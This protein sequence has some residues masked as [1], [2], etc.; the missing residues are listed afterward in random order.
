MISINFVTVASAML[1]IASAAPSQLAPRDESS[2]SKTAQLRLADSSVDRYK[3]LP[4]DEDFV[5][6]FLESQ[7]LFA[8]AKSFPALVGTGAAFAYTT[9]DACSMS[10]LHLH[11]RATEL[12]TVTSGSI[13]TEM[14][15]E[16]AVFDAD[17]Q[18]RVIRTELGP[19]M[20][21]VF[22]A[23]SFHTQ[24]NVDCKPA[25]FVAAFTSEDPG[26]AAVVNGVFALSD[27]VISG[28]FGEAI[29]GEDIDKIRDALPAG[30]GT[31]ID[32][33]LERCNMQKRV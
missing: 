8:D 16:A 6:N 18:Q 9:L 11:P 3:L 19:G 10:F 30:L 1:A 24:L 17:D 25:T 33:C 4:N 23:G 27:G 5:F 29:S 21:T 26:A 22:P 13:L 7:A 20:M 14:F 2:P 31:K 15:P 28:A 12:L 32:Q